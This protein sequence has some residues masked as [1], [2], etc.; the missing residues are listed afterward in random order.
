MDQSYQEEDWHTNTDGVAVMAACIGNH[1]NNK[2]EGL[3]AM[4]SP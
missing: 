1:G 3:K 4:I 2:L